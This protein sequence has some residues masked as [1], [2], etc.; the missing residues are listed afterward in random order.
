MTEEV[1]VQQQNYPP[2]P[3]VL[4][5]AQALRTAKE[6]DDGG[7]LMHAAL[8]LADEVGEFC[9]AVKASFVYDKPFDTE[10]A[11]EELGDILFYISLACHALKIPMDLPAVKNIEKLYKRYPD[12][13]SNEAALARADKEGEGQ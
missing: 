9:K 3:F 5:Q 1:E 4:Y 7:N 12:K 2:Y 8:G 10:N 11:V 13:Y 6:M